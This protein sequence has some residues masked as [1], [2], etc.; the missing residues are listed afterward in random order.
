MGHRRYNHP[1]NP[2]FSD[3]SPWTCRSARSLLVSSIHAT[4]NNTDRAS[5]NTGN[6]NIV[7]SGIA[8]RVNI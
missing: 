1:R 8:T 6:I 2:G 5:A 3:L 4:T 7:N